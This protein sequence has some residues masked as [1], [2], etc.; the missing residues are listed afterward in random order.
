MQFPLVW[1]Y[2]IGNYLRYFGLTLSAFVAIL[3]TTRLDEIAHFTTLGPELGTLFWFI[4]YLIPY[5]LPIAIPISCLIA[6]AILFARLSGQQELTAFRAAGLSVAALATPLLLIATLLAIFNFVMV[7]E[8]A[9]SAH[10]EKGLLRMELRSINPLLILHNKHLMQMRGFYFDTMGSSQMGKVAKEVVFATKDGAH[11][12]LVIAL[13]DT[14]DMEEGFF[15]GKAVTVISPSG[16]SP[17]FDAFMIENVEAESMQMDDFTPLIKQKVWSLQTD[18]LPWNTLTL[19]QNQFNPEEIIAEKF[20]RVSL[21]LAPF[22]FTLMGLAFGFRVGRQRTSKELW[23]AAALTALYLAL[24]FAAK[25]MGKQE[26]QAF[27]LYFIPQILIV[28][29]SLRQLSR[30]SQG[31]VA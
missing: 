13:A 14:L 7:S 28:L 8:V 5:I 27:S 9:T 20:R 23:I 16:Q 19:S 2:L 30:I 4:L 17:A 31:V 10:L 6:G 25:G 3:L 11:D 12:Q 18:H 22:T 24:F 15:N 1:Q 29:F 26:W 21:G